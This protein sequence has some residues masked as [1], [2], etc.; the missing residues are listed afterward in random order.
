MVIRP[1]G[2]IPPKRTAETIT[3]GFHRLIHFA[4]AGDSPVRREVDL[5]IRIFLIDEHGP[6]R[7][8]LAH[9]LESIHGL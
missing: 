4:V 8:I 3:F 5:S 2:P 1:R 7:D 6:A 9:R